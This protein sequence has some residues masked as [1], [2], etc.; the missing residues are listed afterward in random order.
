MREKQHLIF[1]KATQNDLPKIVK[2]L[3][4]DKL[5][6]T[7]EDY[8]IP[9]PIVYSDAFEKIVVDQNQELI[10]VEDD[11]NEIIGTLQLSFIQYLTYQG[12]LR[13]QI[14]SEERRVGKECRSWWSRDH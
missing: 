1:R 14:R 6:K 4:D 3:A 2:M 7:R 11:N 13:A 5:A 12:G 8:Q 10:V 9:L